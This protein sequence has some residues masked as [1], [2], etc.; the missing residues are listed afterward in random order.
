MVPSGESDCL[1]AV[2][3]EFPVSVVQGADLTSLQPT[4]DAVEVEGVLV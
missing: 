3:L 2:L 1:S 4:R